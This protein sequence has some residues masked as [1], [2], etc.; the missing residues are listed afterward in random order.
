M[1]VCYACNKNKPG[2][3]EPFKICDDCKNGEESQAVQ[4][5]FQ[6]IETALQALA[7]QILQLRTELLVVKA[8]LTKQDK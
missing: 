3:P 2:D 4:E 8:M 6:A 5:G 1:F 7:G